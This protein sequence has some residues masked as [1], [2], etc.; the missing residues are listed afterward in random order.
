MWQ[1][2]ET[3]PRDGTEIL[4]YSEIGHTGV[5][6]VRWIALQDFI[7][8]KDAEDFA[9]AGMSESSLEMPDWFAAD[10][11]HG[12]RLSPDCYPTHWMPI[13]AIP[14]NH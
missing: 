13:P 11:C 12:D 10:F 9:N 2:I 5:M 7:T 3:A 14:E 4:A 1:P 8:T 6:L